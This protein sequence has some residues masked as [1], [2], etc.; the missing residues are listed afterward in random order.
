MA[1]Q[2][3]QTREEGK[4][5]QQQ[6]QPIGY[7][8]CDGWRDGYARSA[9]QWLQDQDYTRRESELSENEHFTK[10]MSTISMV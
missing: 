6:H 8:K 1:K 7:V 9:G 3:N 5:N 10:N 4:K 2:T